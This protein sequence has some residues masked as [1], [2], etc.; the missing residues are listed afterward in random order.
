M[1]MNM[2]GKRILTRALTGRQIFRFSGFDKFR[3]DKKD[4]PKKK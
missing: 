4:E 2:I 3:R 1:I